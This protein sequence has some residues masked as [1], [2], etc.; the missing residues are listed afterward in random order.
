MIGYSATSNKWR[1][2][3]R[4]AAISL[5]FA[6]FLTC[7]VYGQQQAVVP[8]RSAAPTSPD[9]ALSAAT[10]HAIVNIVDTMTSMLADFNCASLFP[11]C[12]DTRKGVN[13]LGKR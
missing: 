10:S 8:I 5:A 4:L 1:F 13:I 12:T 6:T 7:L 3:K 9:I 2:I 11:L